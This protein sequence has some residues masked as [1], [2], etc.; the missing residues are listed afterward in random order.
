MTNL[1]CVCIS[2][3]YSSPSALQHSLQVISWIAIAIG[4]WLLTVGNFATS[5]PYPAPGHLENLEAFLIVVIRKVLL[6]SSGQR[7][8]MMLNMLQYTGELPQQRIIQ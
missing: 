1:L 4:Q 8:R 7:P 3:S 5:S 6:M 2:N